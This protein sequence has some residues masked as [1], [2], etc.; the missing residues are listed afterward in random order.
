MKG[1]ESGLPI[2]EG[3][4]KVIIFLVCPS[5]YKLSKSC[6][7]NEKIHSHATFSCIRVM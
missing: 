5:F 6:M 7:S 2:D 4:E 3:T 1:K